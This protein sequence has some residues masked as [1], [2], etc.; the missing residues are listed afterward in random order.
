[1]KEK[2]GDIFQQQSKY[3]RNNLPRS[4]LDW[5]SQPPLYKT[6]PK[7]RHL[8]LPKPTNP[9]TPSLF[10]ILQSRRSIRTYQDAPLTQEQLT[11]ALNDVIHLHRLMEEIL[12][13]LEI[14]Q[15]TE[16][17]FEE[18]KILEDET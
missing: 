10:K 18:C 13:R 9:Q 15:R 7:K 14:I 4:Y 11:Y 5:N 1:M 12:K 2:Y 8:S 6:Y 17:G 3:H 16:W